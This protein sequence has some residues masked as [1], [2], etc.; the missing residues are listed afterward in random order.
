MQKVTTVQLAFT[1]KV[2][3][4]SISTEGMS[5]TATQLPILPEDF[6]SG[7]KVPLAIVQ[8]IWKKAEDLLVSLVPFCQLLD[9]VQSVKWF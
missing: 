7:L 9:M 8:G 4:D 5:C 1:G 2:P 3:G 6:Q